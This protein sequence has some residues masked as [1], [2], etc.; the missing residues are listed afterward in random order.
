M[1]KGLRKKNPIKTTATVSVTDVHTQHKKLHTGGYPLGD[2]SGEKENNGNIGKKLSEIV[3][4]MNKR[5]RE[6]G[7]LHVSDKGS[8][9]PGPTCRG[10]RGSVS[11][12]Y[13]PAEYALGSLETYLTVYGGLFALSGNTLKG[14]AWGEEAAE[15]PPKCIFVG[16]NPGPFGMAQTGIPFGDVQMVKDFLRI[17]QLYERNLSSSSRSILQ[18][19][20][21]SN[22]RAVA[23]CPSRPIEGFECKKS[24]VSGTRLWG[25]VREIGKNRT[26]A[27]QGKE[28]Q[29]DDEQPR[30]KRVKTGTGVEKASV[31]AKAEG[32]KCND[33]GA[34]GLAAQSFF[35]RYF[36]YNYCPL[37]FMTS[38]GR[39]VTPANVG[40]T[41][42]TVLTDVCDEALVESIRVLRP[43]VLVGVGKYAEECCH[44][45][46]SRMKDE[47]KV[48]L[49]VHRILHPSPISPAANRDWSGTVLAQMKEHKLL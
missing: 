36:V 40:S 38:S 27:L 10:G 7:V 6:E 49:P 3:R 24:E 22:A 20:I 28:K 2:V 45:A 12:V 44:R 4:R 13:N 39:N 18:E 34:L 46:A 26:N 15:N 32:E 1:R 37:S 9:E 29:V 11:F 17:P 23:Q 25:L 8:V 31:A 41:L 21:L 5:M 43:D 30:V 47:E 14:K 33:E 35:Q 19:E 48:T 42:S 16:M